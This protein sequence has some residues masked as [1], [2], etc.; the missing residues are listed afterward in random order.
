MLNLAPDKAEIPLHSRSL[1]PIPPLSTPLCS[2]PIR[3]GTEAE[4][5][6]CPPKFVFR[7]SLVPPDRSPNLTP[8][9]RFQRKVNKIE[10]AEKRK[11]GQHSSDAP[12]P[13]NNAPQTHGRTKRRTP[14]THTHPKCHYPSCHH[15]HLH[16]RFPPPHPIRAHCQ[17]HISPPN[18]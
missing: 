1:S 15:H 2:L 9:S 17:P 16:E 4:C 5:P 10:A 8:A 7:P 13:P 11:G 12:L 14:Q 6:P 18:P 3:E